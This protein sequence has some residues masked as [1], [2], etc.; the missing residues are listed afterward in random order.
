MLFSLPILIPVALFIVGL[1]VI[2]YKERNEKAK[3]SLED[4]GRL[5]IASSKSW[6]WRM[7][8]LISVIGLFQLF[9]LIPHNKNQLLIEALAF[10]LMVVTALGISTFFRFQAFAKEGV[11]DSYIQAMKTYAKA[12]FAMFLI[13]PLLVFIIGILPLLW[14]ILMN[15]FHPHSH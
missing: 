7:L 9:K 2:T 12:R 14:T 3:L 11:P 4:Q 6:F 15:F 1:I 13:L 8:P 10:V 5:S